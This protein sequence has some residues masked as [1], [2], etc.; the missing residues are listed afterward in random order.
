M[1]SYEE[2]LRAVK[3]YIELGKLAQATIRKLGYLSY[4]PK[5]GH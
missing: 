1:N 2:R 3:L 4:P 5:F